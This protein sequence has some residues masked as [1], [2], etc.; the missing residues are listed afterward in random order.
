MSWSQEKEIEFHIILRT[1]EFNQEILESDIKLIKDF[2]DNKHKAFFLEVYYAS[3]QIYGY[4][5]EKVKKF[6]NLYLDSIKLS[7]QFDIADA[8]SS[9]SNCSTV[10]NNIY[11]PTKRQIEESDFSPPCK[12]VVVDDS[13]LLSVSVESDNMLGTYESDII[14]HNI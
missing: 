1:I 10:E 11:K 12:K 7:K 5:K 8:L 3:F 9:F 13:E 6:Y 4:N 14:G 2:T